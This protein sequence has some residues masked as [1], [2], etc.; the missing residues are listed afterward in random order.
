LEYRTMAG[1]LSMAVN[2]AV[3]VRGGDTFT[4]A[5]SKA[6]AGCPCATLV[7]NATIAALS[8]NARIFHE[9]NSGAEGASLDFTPALV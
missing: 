2:P 3:P 7:A 9:Y 5:T 8:Q 6:G 4:E 1:S